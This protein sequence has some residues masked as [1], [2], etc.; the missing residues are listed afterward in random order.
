VVRGG[1]SGFPLVA[2]PPP[3]SRLLAFWVAGA[4]PLRP[5]RPLEGFCTS[6][7]HNWQSQAVR[8]S[9]ATK[10][11]DWAAGHS[12]FGSLPRCASGSTYTLVHMIANICF[13][14]NEG[15]DIEVSGYLSCHLFFGH[16]LFTDYS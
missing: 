10:V 7:F 4:G 6:S 12:I 11:S 13:F 14:I 16:A 3:Y 15:K 8:P 1:P 2:D 9:M 5:L